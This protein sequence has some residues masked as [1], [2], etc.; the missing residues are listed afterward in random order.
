LIIFFFPPRYSRGTDILV[1]VA[2]YALA[3]GA[4]FCDKEIFSAGQLVGGHALKHLFAA[5]AIFWI[6]RMIWKRDPVTGPA[7]ATNAL[8]GEG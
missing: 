8:R 4:E 7:S 5:L 3:K 1:A 6:L 2:V